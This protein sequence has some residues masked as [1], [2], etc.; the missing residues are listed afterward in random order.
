L[1]PDPARIIAP[2]TYDI[3][4]PASRE[5]DGSD[6]NERRLHRRSTGEGGGEPM[7]V[8]PLVDA[9]H[10]VWDLAVRDQEWITGPELA[11]LRRSFSL[12]DLHPLADRA[13]VGATVM[14]QTLTVPEETPGC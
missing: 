4:F 9:H 13:G 6:G 2:D 5:P 12:S 11:P 7:S 8:T 3:R 1:S 10:H 14:V